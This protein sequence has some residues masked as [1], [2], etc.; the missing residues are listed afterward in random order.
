MNQSKHERVVVGM[1]KLANAEGLTL[2]T[3]ITTAYSGELIILFRAGKA[4][5]YC[6]LGYFI[7][8]PE[9]VLEPFCEEL[10]KEIRS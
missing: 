1:E 7:Q 2:D 8:N 5:V 9:V 6:K 4:Q 10:I 3:C